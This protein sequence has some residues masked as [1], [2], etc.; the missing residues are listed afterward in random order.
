LVKRI[1]FQI[2]N[3]FRIIAFW[4]LIPFLYIGCM[5]AIR[6]SKVEITIKD[7]VLRRQVN[8]YA[9]AQEFECVVDGR[10]VIV[11]DAYKHKTGDRVQLI[12]RDGE[13]YSIRSEEFPDNGVSLTDRVRF[14]Y[15]ET[16]KGND[17]F[18]LI[19]YILLS[20]LTFK[21][22]KDFRR[23]YFIPAIITHVFG[24]I[25]AVLFVL[26]CYWLDVITLI[27]YAVVF[28]IF[29]IVWIIVRNVNKRTVM[30]K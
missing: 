29:W 18:I 1:I 20:I 9:S 11:V 6:E 3:S 13:Y 14:R 12:Y 10:S 7:T 5:A 26:T 22:R 21:T 25:T 8:H 23:D 19:A 16:T 17:A 30:D 2:L 28:A 4:L 15:V 27:F 24:V